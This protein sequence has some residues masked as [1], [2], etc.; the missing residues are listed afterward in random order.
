MDLKKQLK[1]M[2]KHLDEMEDKYTETLTNNQELDYKLQEA[3]AI[4][5]EDALMHKMMI[6]DH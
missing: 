3:Q 1:K 4:A 6:R 2:Q 5:K